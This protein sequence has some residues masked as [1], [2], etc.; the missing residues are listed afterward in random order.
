[1]EA[2]LNVSY[3]PFNPE[4]CR[5]VIKT[6]TSTLKAWTFEPKATGPKA[7]QWPTKIVLGAKAWPRGLHH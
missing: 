4:T 6:K 5:D 1:M 2:Y 7:R 3:C